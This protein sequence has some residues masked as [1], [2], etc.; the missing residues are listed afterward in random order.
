ME[1]KRE[2]QMSQRQ[3]RDEHSGL[4]RAA[5]R[6]KEMIGGVAGKAK[7]AAVTDAETFVTQAAIGDLYEC[8]AARLAIAR[9]KSDAVRMIAEHMLDDHTTST[10]QLQSTLRSLKDAAPPPMELDKRRREMLENL[11][12]AEDDEFDERYLDQQVMAHREA[13]TLFESFASKG[14]DPSLRLFAIAT[15]PGLVRHLEMVEAAQKADRKP[16]KKK[17]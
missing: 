6:A 2:K 1:R 9:S 10:H 8:E 4:E 15:L 12:E 5:S 14:D 7:A 16:A 11:E 13:I 3:P 17:A